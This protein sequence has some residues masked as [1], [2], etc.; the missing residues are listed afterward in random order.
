MQRREFLTAT[1]G[2][3][4][5]AAALPPH[6]QGPREQAL[7]V[8]KATQKEIDHGLEL[9]AGS[10][11]IEPYGFSPRQ[12]LDGDAL[13]AAMEAGASDIE[14]Q[15]LTEEMLMTRCVHSA[16]ERKEYQLGW[17]ASGITCIFQNAGE[18]GQ[19]PM[20][21]MKRLARF[22]YVTDMLGG[23]VTR[24]VRPDDIVATQRRNGHCMAMG[25]ERRPAHGAVGFG[26]R[27]AALYSGVFPV[28]GAL[29]A[30][31]L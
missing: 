12:A 6:I 13:R 5:A 3:A 31:Y 18:E 24:A 14:I 1:A 2:L 27:R 17:E 16:A 4:S 7:A 26:G 21:L 10:L 29:D 28:G 30:P 25:G 9:H 11:V 23:F 19:S 15:D 20:V 8:L 22:T